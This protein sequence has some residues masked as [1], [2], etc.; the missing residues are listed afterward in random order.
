[1]AKVPWPFTDQAVNC[2]Q[3]E[4][5]DKSL[6]IDREKCWRVGEKWQIAAKKYKKLPFKET[7]FG[8]LAKNSQY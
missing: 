1:M 5:K 7:L 6:S 4:K 2:F 8:G 3:G